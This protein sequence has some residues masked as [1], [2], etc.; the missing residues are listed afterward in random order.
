MAEISGGQRFFLWQ[1]NLT[2]GRVAAAF[3]RRQ[4]HAGEVNKAHASAAITPFAANRRFNAADGRVVI[5]VF[6]A[7]TKLN[8]LV[9]N[10]FIV[11]KCGHP[12]AAADHLD[13][14]VEEFITHPGVVAHAEVRLGGAQATA[15]F[16]HG[17]RERVDRIHRLPPIVT[18]W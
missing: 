10:D 4:H 17:P 11:I 5:G 13:A 12:E 14:G 9:D 3:Q 2:G 8:K 7:D 15:G 1:E 6:A 18:F 16:Q